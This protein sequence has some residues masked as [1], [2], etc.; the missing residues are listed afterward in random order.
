ME[1]REEKE[2]K[3]KRRK[4]KSHLGK[5]GFPGAGPSLLAVQHVASVRCN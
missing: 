2:R 4:K 5:K 1:K 3:K